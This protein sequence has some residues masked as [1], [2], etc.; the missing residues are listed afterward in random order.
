MEFFYDNKEDYNTFVKSL[1]GLPQNAYNSTLI[2]GL[3]DQLWLNYQS[4]MLYELCIPSVA[5][6]ILSILSFIYSL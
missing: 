1:V 5:L 3:L 4:K 6:S 2:E